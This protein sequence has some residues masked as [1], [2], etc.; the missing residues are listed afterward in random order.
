MNGMN[1]Y[2]RL[3]R[4]V[5]PYKGR[6]I[7]AMLSSQG[8]ALAT[9][10]V[11]AT[12]YIII[13]GMQNRTEVI[14]NNIPHVP[15]LMNIRFPAQWVPFLIVLVFLLRSFFAYL[16]EYQMA[17]VGI[18]AI[19]K[20]RDDLYEHLVSL[21]HDFYSKGRTG[22]FLSRIMNDVGSIQGAITDVINDFVKQPFV[23]LYNIPMIF[24]FGGW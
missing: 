9:A 17:S 8:Y 11:S 18:R 1:I 21:S 3:I 10:M 6:L 12:L 4:Y 20:I 14:I 24:I 19:R 22:D 23:I 15:F 2:R 7:L 16:S 13:N 5:S